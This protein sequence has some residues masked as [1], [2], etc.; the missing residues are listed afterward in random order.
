M[1]RIK[2]ERMRAVM[3]EAFEHPTIV[4]YYDLVVRNAVNK[5][6][7]FG[8]VARYERLGIAEMEIVAILDDRTST[9]CREM[10][11]R[12]IPVSVA[13]EFVQDVMATKMDDLTERFAWPLKDQA[14]CVNMCIA[15]IPRQVQDNDGNEHGDQSNYK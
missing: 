8:R 7:N 6:R 15:A 2:V 13:S 9:T 10:N 3:G 4:N 5:S 1:N 12:R 14:F 11:G